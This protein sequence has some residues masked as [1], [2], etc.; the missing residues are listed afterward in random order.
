MY[1]VLL[2]LVIAFS[3]C[4]KTKRALTGFFNAGY[5]DVQ[6]RQANTSTTDCTETLTGFTCETRRGN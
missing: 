3:G 5:R 1:I 6:Q 4:T 2:C